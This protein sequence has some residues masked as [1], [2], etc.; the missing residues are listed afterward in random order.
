[1]L[2]GLDLTIAKARAFSL[3]CEVVV[4]DGPL[5]NPFEVRAKEGVILKVSK[6]C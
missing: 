5:A 2:A 1:M 6:L 3:F 4:E